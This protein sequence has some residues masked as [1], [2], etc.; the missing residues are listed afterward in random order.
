MFEHYLIIR[1]FVIDIDIDIIIIVIL[2]VVV[3]F[4]CVRLH[5][6]IQLNV[7]VFLQA[8]QKTN[9]D[10][11]PVKRLVRKLLMIMSRP[12][13]LLECLVN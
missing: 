10:I 9:L 12:A 1:I 5:V 11:S 3:V 4:V 13:R 8:H 7:H 2:V 6:F